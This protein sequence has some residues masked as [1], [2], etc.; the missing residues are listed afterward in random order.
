MYPGVKIVGCEDGKIPGC[1]IPVRNFD[2][3]NVFDGK[4]KVKCFST[5]GTSDGTDGRMLYYFET[6]GCINGE[7]TFEK[8]ENFG[9]TYKVVHN[10]NRCALTGDSVPIGGLTEFAECNAPSVLL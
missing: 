10:V 6:Y 8:M 9:I 3:F 2:T 1:N 4:V 5:T 7:E